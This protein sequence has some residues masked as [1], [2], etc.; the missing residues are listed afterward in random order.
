MYHITTCSSERILH[1]HSLHV[2]DAVSIDP[3]EGLT[4][5]NRF[6]MLNP[7]LYLQWPEKDSNHL[8][9]ERMQFY[10]V[11]KY[12]ANILYMPKSSSNAFEVHVS[13]IEL[14]KNLP[15]WHVADVSIMQEDGLSRS[16]FKC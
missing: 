9:D 13:V 14:T 3:Q 12:F 5:M 4:P 16:E 7:P 11:S 2:Q 8:G 15:Q 10:V 6:Y 1:Q